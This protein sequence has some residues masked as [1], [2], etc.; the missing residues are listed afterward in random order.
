MRY[1][2][3]VGVKNTESRNRRLEDPLVGGRGLVE[4]EKGKR[5][6]EKGRGRGRKTK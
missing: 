3:E 6:D 2:D 4:K 1:V 5:T